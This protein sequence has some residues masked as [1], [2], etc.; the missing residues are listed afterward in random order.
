MHMGYGRSSQISLR[1]PETL[2]REIDRQ[3][4][5]RRLSRS[6][7]IRQLLEAQLGGARDAELDHPYAR[8]RD[9][10]G[11][12]SGGPTDLGRR[13]REYLTE[14]VRDRRR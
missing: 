9:L 4:R 10:V 2:L 6:D 12:V 11:S 14:L 8:V 3:A 1:L 5:Q 7:V 13:H